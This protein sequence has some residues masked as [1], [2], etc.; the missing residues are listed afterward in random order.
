MYRIPVKG[1]VRKSA[2]SELPINVYVWE[3]CPS[4]GMAVLWMIYEGVEQ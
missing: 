3:S 1:L 4:L 2:A